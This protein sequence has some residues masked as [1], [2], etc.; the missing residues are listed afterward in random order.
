[1]KFVFRPTT[2]EK[3]DDTQIKNTNNK[4]L[5]SYFP[6]LDKPKSSIVF[7]G[8]NGWKSTKKIK[9]VNLFGVFGKMYNENCHDFD[10][11]YKL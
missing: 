6:V 2:R 7:R 11:C 1:M 4:N 9:I 5:Y 8:R 3:T 10:Y